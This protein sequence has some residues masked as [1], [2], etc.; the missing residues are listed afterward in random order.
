MA[1]V[2]D[3]ALGDDA[4]PNTGE[5]GERDAET[6]VGGEALDL[7]AFGFSASAVREYEDLAVSEDA[8]DVEDEDFDLIGAC[9]RTQTHIAH[10]SWLER[11]EIIPV[12]PLTQPVNLFL[13]P[14][15]FNPDICL[16]YLIDLAGI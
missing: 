5:A 6:V 11:S 10:D 7:D 3:S 12:Y 2:C 8:V 16:L 13:V 1:T 4:D 15:A 14:V 9:F